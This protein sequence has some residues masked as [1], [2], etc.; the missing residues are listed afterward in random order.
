MELHD[1]HGGHTLQHLLIAICASF[2]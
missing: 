2:F 1:R